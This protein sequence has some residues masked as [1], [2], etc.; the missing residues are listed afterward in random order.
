VID[1][2][3]W[4]PSWPGAAQTLNDV[5]L[6][7][8]L[9]HCRIPVQA[10]DQTAINQISTQIAVGQASGKSVQSIAMG[11]RAYVGGDKELALTIAWTVTAWAAQATS[12]AG[13]ARNGI[14][15]LDWLAGSPNECV[16]CRGNAAA[17]PYALADFPDLP[18]HP[19]CTCAS[20]PH[21]E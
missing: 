21:F 8:V 1:W 15:M 9:E 10:L 12:M 7:K 4:K 17:S 18:A 14:E 13:Y 3:A 19:R 16:K 11:L 20:S 5:G 6:A 2:S